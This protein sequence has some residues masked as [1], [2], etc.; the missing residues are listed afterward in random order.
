[1]RTML[2][3]FRDAVARAPGTEVF[4]ASMAELDAASD[5]FAAALLDRGFLFG[6]R[7]AIA[8]PD[9]PNLVI[10]VV[11][12]WK[13]G[14]SAVLADPA[15]STAELIGLLTESHATVLF[16][17]HDG[18]HDAVVA[19]TDVH[20]VIAG[21]DHLRDLLVLHAGE[22]PLASAPDAEAIAVDTTT[23]GAMASAATANRADRIGRL[24][25]AMTAPG[26]DQR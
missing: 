17:E 15:A 2:D 23:Q 13:A 16:S 8:A 18:A 24:A 9:G 19:H 1:M 21:A 22:Q 11:G 20:T 3:V 14:G 26:G 12:A 25:F 6:D 4:G 7:L 5:A 10:A